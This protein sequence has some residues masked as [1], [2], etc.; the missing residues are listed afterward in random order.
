MDKIGWYNSYWVIFSS[1]PFFLLL[2]DPDYEC[3]KVF[4]IVGTKLL[5]KISGTKLLGSVRVKVLGDSEYVN[6]L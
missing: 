1:F 6:N 2:T 3:V 5:V 4:N